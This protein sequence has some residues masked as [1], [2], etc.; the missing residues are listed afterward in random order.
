MPPPFPPVLFASTAGLLPIKITPLP[1]DALT[2]SEHARLTFL[3]HVDKCDV[4][5]IEAAIDSTCRDISCVV[6]S[7]TLNEKK[8]SFA[9]K[10]STQQATLRI[11]ITSITLPRQA[12]LF[13]VKSVARIVAS[14]L[15]VQEI[16]LQYTYHARSEG[17]SSLTWIL[18][19]IFLALA[20]FAACLV[21]CKPWLDPDLAV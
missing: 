11:L 15:P 4:K 16:T 10:L 6:E 5:I 18:P 9:R 20:L 8:D 13:A 3:L 12:F 1:Q 14:V 19:T 21:V 2:A 17:S 7:C